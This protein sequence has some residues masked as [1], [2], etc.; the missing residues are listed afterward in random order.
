MIQLGW[1]RRAFKGDHRGQQDLERE[2]HAGEGCV[3][4]LETWPVHTHSLS[5]SLTRTHTFTRS[6]SHTHIHRHRHTISHTETHTLFLSLS[7]SQTLSHT[8]S[9]A[10]THMHTN[11]RVSMQTPIHPPPHKH[12]YTHTHSLT[13][14][15][16]PTPTLTTLAKI[17]NTHNTGEDQWRVRTSWITLI[18]TMRKD[19]L[20]SMLLHS[21]ITADTPANPTLL[22]STKNPVRLHS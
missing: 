17:T 13:H 20:H 15:R 18:P 19:S 1:S 6:L 9:R 8:L 3:E 2:G 14:S 16:Q 22:P 21:T 11:T 12:T 10:L 4:S 5:R 7:L